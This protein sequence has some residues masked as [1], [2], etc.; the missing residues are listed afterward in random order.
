MPK[1]IITTGGTGGHIFPALATCEELKANW[2]DVDILFMGATY[3]AEAKLAAAAGLRFRGLPGKGVLGKGWKAFPAMAANMLALLIA[4]AEV[5]DFAPCVVAAFGGYA[6]FPAALAA[7]I[8]GIPLL[9]HE[10]NAIVGTVNKLLGRLAATRC[11]SLPRTQG[12]REPYV[13]TGNPVRNAIAQADRNR[14][15]TGRRLLVLGG[16]QGATALNRQIVSILKDLRA[17]DVQL[18]HQ[19]GT[20]DIEFVRNA[21][22]EAG[23]APECARPFID[24]MQEAYGWADL[25]FCR[26]G[27][28]TVAELCIAGLPA[29]LVPFPAAIHDHQTLNAQAML[30]AGAARLLP[31]SELQKASGLILKLLGEPA[32]LKE[33]SRATER[34][35]KPDA[36]ALVAG[37]IMLLCGGNR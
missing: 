34:I 9:L 31:E 37:Q 21:Y 36:A 6:S 16:S 4:L 13:F 19:T 30:Q 7:R 2:P 18:L 22:A 24:N 3:G 25:A 28:S 20:K 17:Q 12:L 15:G 5:K 14:T 1:I 33:M 10:Q 35:R 11:A 29:V 26:A 8:L 27:A 23:Y 32:T